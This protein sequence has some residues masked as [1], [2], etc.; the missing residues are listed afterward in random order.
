VSAYHQPSA[1]SGVS[2]PADAGLRQR[3]AALDRANETRRRRAGVKRDLRAG[4]VSFADLLADPPAWLLT[5][6]VYELLLEMPR[7]GRSRANT[8]LSRSGVLA[9]TTF[10][11]ITLPGR[12][13]LLDELA[14]SPARGSL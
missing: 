4:R 9:T 6:S 11:S 5:A 13:A 12:R 10:E 14:R 8:A 2:A 1:R 7:V 3:R